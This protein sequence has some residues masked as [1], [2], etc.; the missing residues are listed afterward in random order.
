MKSELEQTE[1]ETNE[2]EKCNLKRTHLIF[3]YSNMYFTIGKR[4]ESLFVYTDIK[5]SIFIL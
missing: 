5:I 4:T 1:I 2:N 3:S